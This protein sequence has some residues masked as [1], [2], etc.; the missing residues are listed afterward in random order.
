MA[1]KLYSG[2]KGYF[3]FSACSMHALSLGILLN[4]YFRFSGWKWWIYSNRQV[5][6]SNMETKNRSKRERQKLNLLPSQTTILQTYIMKYRVLAS[7]KI[8]VTLLLVCVLL[9]GKFTRHVCSHPTSTPDAWLMAFL[10]HCLR[11]TIKILWFENSREMV[12]DEF[13]FF[14]E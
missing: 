3:L 1:R 2:N 12:G 7:L 5:F 4:S 6:Y 11:M 13:S 14:S 9:L 8:K 10:G